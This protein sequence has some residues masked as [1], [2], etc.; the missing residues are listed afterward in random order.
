MQGQR[1]SQ[2]QLSKYWPLSFHRLVVTSFLLVCLYRPDYLF[3]KDLWYEICQ[4]S[5]VR[6]PMRQPNNGTNED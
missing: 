6:S 4:D 2:F 5:T 1:A 3:I